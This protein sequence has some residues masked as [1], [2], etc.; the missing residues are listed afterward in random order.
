MG[1]PIF[2]FLIAVISFFLSYTY[3]QAFAEYSVSFLQKTILHFNFF[4]TKNQVECIYVQKI[5]IL[6]S[7]QHINGL[8]PQDKELYSSHHYKYKYV[9]II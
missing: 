4:L 5:Y 1:S 2:F 8:L 7:P 9:L 6:P 3:R